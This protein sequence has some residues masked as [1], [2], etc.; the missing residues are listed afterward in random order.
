MAPAQK[1]FTK[2]IIFEIVPHNAMILSGKCAIIETV[3]AAFGAE[4]KA[5]A[6]GAAAAQKI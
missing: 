2:N 5:T 1:T 6:N 3:D 4:R